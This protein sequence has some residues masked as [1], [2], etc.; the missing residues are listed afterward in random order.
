LTAAKNNAIISC[1]V[2][3][4]KISKLFHRMDS[5]FLGEGED[6]SEKNNQRN[7]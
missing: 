4:Q 1:I 7:V 3:L 6:Q 2:K 5:K